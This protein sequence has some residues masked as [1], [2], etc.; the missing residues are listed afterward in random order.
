MDEMKT[1]QDVEICINGDPNRV[2]RFNPNDSFLAEKFY[3][4]QGTFK[5]KLREFEVKVKTFSNR[6]DDNGIPDD[7]EKRIE[8]VKDLCI[9]LRGEI[10]N[11]LGAGTSQIA[12]GDALDITAIESFVSG[13]VPY[14]GKA[15]KEKVN[16][17][18]RK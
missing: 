7:I 6:T 18:A 9:F 4:M 17:Y 5:Q 12:F 8:L 16:K 10:D 13:I 15:R 2:I 1:T 3:R 14:F 11:F